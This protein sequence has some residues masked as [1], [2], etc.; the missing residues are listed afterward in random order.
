MIE[1]VCKKPSLMLNQLTG[2]AIA[3]F[4]VDEYTLKQLDNLDNKDYKVIIKKAVKGR[5]M[6]QND[7]MWVLIGEISKKLVLSK[8]EVYRQY[9][10]DYGVYK[11]IPIK[12]E[13]VDD[14]ISKW[15][16]GGLGWVC[17][18]ARDSTIKG[19]SLVLAF[20]GSS[21]YTTEEMSVLIEAIV[22]DCEDMGINTMPLE[23][24]LKWEV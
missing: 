11:P 10:R 17:E 1:F 24:I 9:I 22:R 8:I 6:S 5:T 12:N 16:Q 18:T 4:K 15:E 3:T 14:F 2:E 21:T 7:Y 13:A 23:E 19:Y 20:F